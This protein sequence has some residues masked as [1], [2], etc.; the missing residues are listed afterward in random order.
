MTGLL[1]RTFF[2]KEQELKYVSV[3]LNGDLKPQVKFG[4]SSG[5]VVLNELQWYILV[6]IQE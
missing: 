2:F 5:H 4:T 3:Y 1:R 6:T